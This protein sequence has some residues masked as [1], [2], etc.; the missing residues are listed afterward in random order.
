[1]K[2]RKLLATKAIQYNKKPCTD[3]DNLWNALHSSYNTTQNRPINPSILKE[4]PNIPTIQWLSFLVAELCNALIKCNNSSTP[5]SD[6]ISWCYLKSIL[7]DPKCAANIVNIANICISFRYWPIHFKKLTSIIIPKP[8]KTN[9]NI[10]KAFCPIVLL[11]T[12]DKLIEKIISNCLQVYT[13]FFDF[14]HSH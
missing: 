7:S 8:N 10:L 14:L 5:G 1:V 9:Y 2:K 12:M 13:I 3:L 4:I 6:H 11:N